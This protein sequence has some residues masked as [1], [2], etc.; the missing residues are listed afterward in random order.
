MPGLVVSA[1]PPPN[2]DY[3]D[4]MTVAQPLPPL[5]Q[6]MAEAKRILKRVAGFSLAINLLVLTSPLSMLQVYDRVLSARSKPTLLY[7]TLFALACLAVL[8]ALELVRSR[9]L[10]RM[11]GQFD[12]LLADKVFTIVLSNGRS[13]QSFRDLDALRTFLTGSGM[14]ALLDAP[15]TPI[16]LALVYL[17]HPMLGHVALFGVVS[18]LALGLL[19]ERLT[20]KPLAEAGAEMATSTRFAELSA[21]NAEAV[22]AMGML[23][24]LQAR[25]RGSHVRGLALQTQASDRAGDIAA[26][27]KFV[28][29]FLQV[30][31]LGMGAYL[32]IAQECTGGVMIAASIIMGRGLAPVETSIGA[33]RGFLMARLAYWR[34]KDEFADLQRETEPMPLP[35]PTGDVLVEKLVGGPPKVAKP[36][37]AGVSFHLGAGNCLGIAGP[38]AAGKSTLA[39]LLVGVWRPASGEVRLD[40]VNIADWRREEVGPH[41]GYLPQDI[42][43]FP[44]SVAVNIARFGK[45]DAEKV[46]EAAKL[47]GA[48]EMILELPEGYDTL[49]GIGGNELSGGQRQKIALARA[50]YG[51]PALIVLDEPTSNLDSEGEAAVC[52]AIQELKQRQRTV[53]VI[54]HRLILLT[55]TDAM[56][57]LQKGVITQFGK[58]SE[59]MPQVTRPA[60]ARPEQSLTAKYPG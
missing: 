57:V 38:S 28:R 56:M 42:E 40:H 7:L 44:A 8:G 54:A 1:A 6:A 49:I 15:W 32:V 33:W 16:Y 45:V 27:A 36:V 55:T 20:R 34:L 19:N 31:I 9:I 18:L 14:L 35:P 60:D 41:I 50:F 25:W 53:V 12:A 46:V 23:P 48:H 58:T 29:F 3:P 10:V 24:G 13:G 51:L 39:R 59:V 21:R 17:L 4:R 5:V 30:A 52:K 11:G 43:L 26:T 37:I 2:Q 22:R 47:A